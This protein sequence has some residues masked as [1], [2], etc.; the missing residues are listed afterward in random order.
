MKLLFATFVLY[1]GWIGLA[2]AQ[3]YRECRQ[4]DLC[5]CDDCVKNFL[6]VASVLE[7][8]WDEEEILS[9]KPLHNIAF[10][11]AAKGWN[12]EFGDF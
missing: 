7:F 5:N 12:D 11:K 10:L 2:S 8:L 6:I 1:L 9:G 4:T 3:P